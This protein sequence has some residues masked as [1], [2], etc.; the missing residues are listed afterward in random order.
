MMKRCLLILAALIV[1]L[2]PAADSAFAQTTVGVRAFEQYCATCHG[3]PSSK[4]AAPDESQLRRLTSEEI[5]A[6]FGKAPHTNFQGLTDEQKLR[7]TQ[8][9]GG[10]TPGIA[11]IADA[12]RMSNHCSSN[13]PISGLSAKPSWNGWGND[14]TTN[15]RFQPAKA[16]GLSAD[17]VP[18][19]TLKWAFGFPGAEEVYGQP[20]IAAGR[21]FIGVDTGAVYSLDAATGCVYWSFQADAGVRNAISIGPVKGQGSAKYGIYFGDIRANV[22]MLDATTGKLLWKVKVEDHPVAR[23]TGAP[24]LYQGRLYVPVASSEESTA[25]L[26]TVYPCCT[27]RG[28][29][30]ALDANTGR[31]I[32]KTYTVQEAPKPTRK[33]S[34]GIQLWTPN[35]AAVWNSPTVDTKRHALYIGT[36]DAY[37]EPAAKT[38]DAIV[39]LDMTTGKILW[40]HQD[41][42]NDAWLVGCGSQYSSENCP[43]DLGPDYDFGS[44]PI[45]RALPDGH[46]ILVAGQKSGMVWGH[47][48]DQEGTVLWKAQLV[49][50]L[51]LG[52]ITFGGAADEQNAYFGLKTG[53]VAAVQLT[54]G[55]KRWFTPVE[56]PPGAPVGGQNAA[57][58]VIP[59]VVF[60]SGWDGVVRAF[61]SNDGHLL[62]QYNTIRDFQT[63]N[64]VTAKGGSMGAPG[65]TVADGV[66]FVGSGYLFGAWGGTPG[67]VLLAFS[68]Q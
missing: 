29:V 8:R 27:F 44:S 14:A 40:A 38:T 13:P 34:K 25:G 60:S 22:Y 46:R 37:L 18:R 31:K 54:T 47:D 3:N 19:L 67:N 61:A 26:S 10:R 42:E 41:T 51:A 23:V 57:L 52:I 65:P 21:V 6:A 30:V 35:G 55:D 66:L 16:A 4:V 63:V 48:P 9:L 1:I 64:G 49:Q 15:A 17:Q 7:I 43:K 68:V 53:G 5:E 56:A 24:T 62:W 36:G 11:Q 32:W 58:T 12:R 33:T 50:D 45:L 2:L 39:A 28:S 59:G 20:T